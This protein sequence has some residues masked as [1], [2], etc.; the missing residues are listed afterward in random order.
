M[1]VKT[2]PL[3][4]F[5]PQTKENASNF[6]FSKFIKRVKVVLTHYLLFFF[7]SLFLNKRLQCIQNVFS[8]LCSLI[9]LEYLFIKHFQRVYKCSSH[10][11]LYDNCSSFKN[12][13]KSPIVFLYETLLY[14]SSIFIF[15]CNMKMNLDYLLDCVWEHLALLR[16]YTKKR[17]G[18]FYI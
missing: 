7:P 10:S 12:L 17:G 5:F 13:L 15:S 9:S 8:I 16:V 6:L 1:I 2:N 4:C 11:R 14:Q 3:L 18:K